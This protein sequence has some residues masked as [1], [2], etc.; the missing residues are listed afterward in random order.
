MPQEQCKLCLKTKELQDSHFM[1]AA[2]YR[3]TRN[4]AAV[5]PNPAVITSRGT[6]QTSQQMQDFLLC[7]DCEELF[8]KN[9]E[10]YV[11]SQV[12]RSGKF[13]LLG[14]LRKATPTKIAKPVSAGMTSSLSL[15]W[16]ETNWDILPSVFFGE[17]RFMFGG[18]PNQHRHLSIWGPTKMHSGD[19]SLG[20]H[21]FQR[22]LCCFSSS[23]LIQPLKT[24][25][26]CRAE[27]ERSKTRHTLSKQEG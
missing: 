2:L 15:M 4:A 24:V 13:P 12:N 8:N 5:N 21:A 7:K 3:A 27:V 25:S 20:K 26:T 14:T 11:M 17:R 23:A 9:G 22:T 19:T 18:N 1:P 16:I 6:V 10:K